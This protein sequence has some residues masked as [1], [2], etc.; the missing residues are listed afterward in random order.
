MSK[1]APWALFFAILAS[2]NTSIIKEQAVWNALFSLLFLILLFLFFWILTDGLDQFGWLYL[3]I[4][5]DI[6]LI[7]LATFRLIRLVTFDKIFA[8][9]RNMFLVEQS[10]GTYVKPAGGIRRTVAELME[11]LW[12]TGLWAAL[13]ATTLYFIADI[14]RFVILVLAVA[15]LG[16]FLQVFSQMIG[17]IGK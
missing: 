6:V 7:A 8:F 2:M 3:A 17:R 4:P 14:G 1:R 12:C 5:I 13:F 16:S 10:D 9:V 15:A 11:C